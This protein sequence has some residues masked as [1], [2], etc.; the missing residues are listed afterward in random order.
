MAK[1]IKVGNPANESEKKAIQH[2]ANNLPKSWTI[3][4]NFELEAKQ[5]LE[6]DLAV[7][8]PHAVYLVDVKGIRGKFTEIGNKWFAGEN[9]LYPSPLV[10]LRQNTKILSNLLKNR[11]KEIAE[12]RKV[13]IHP[14]ILLT[15]DNADILDKDGGKISDII[16][17][18][19]CNKYFNDKSRVTPYRLNNINQYHRHVIKVITGGTP[20]SKHLIFGK[21]K[22]KEELF[23]SARYTE[24]RATRTEP[25]LENV[26]SILRIYNVNQYQDD[27]ASKAEDN[28]LSVAFRASRKIPD[29][30]RIISVNEYFKTESNDKHIFVFDDLPNE[31]ARMNLHDQKGKLLL[32][33]SIQIAYDILSGLEHVH[34]NEVIFRNINPKSILITNDFRARLSNLEFSRIEG[35]QN[36]TIASQINNFLEKNYQSPECFDE[37]SEASIAG[38]IYSA[39]VTIFEMLT[40]RLPFKN[41]EELFDRAGKFPHKPSTLNSNLANGF[42]KWLQKMCEFES[43]NRFQ[44]A[45]EAQIELTNLTKDYDKKITTRVIPKSKHITNIFDLPKNKVL[46]NRFEIQKKLGQGRFGVSYKVFDIFSD[47][48]KVMKLFKGEYPNNLDQMSQEFSILTKLPHYKYVIKT[49]GAGEI[50]INQNERIPYVLFEYIEGKSIS[51]YLKSKKFS[52]NDSLIIAKQVI[53]GLAHLHLNGVYHLDIKPVNIIWTNS[54]TRIIDFNIATLKVQNQST[55]EGTNKYLPPMF[56]QSSKSTHEINVDRDLYAFGIT[57]YE[58]L[59][60][61]YPFAENDRVNKS[62]PIDLRTH[63]NMKNINPDFANL[64]MKV[65]SPSVVDRFKSAESIMHEIRNLTI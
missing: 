7:L 34:S 49:E 25:E 15:N 59:T 33:Q 3:L 32:S 13:H 47:S 56:D 22:V 37:P 61:Q 17:L 2:L 8:S 28:L 38:D 31:S 65:I 27:K 5:K 23:K 19:D 4:H 46:D 55:E 48:S 1:I 29:H 6:I 52:V 45:S 24:F 50:F 60:C 18:A 57:I 54:E 12:I 40:G 35:D 39:G 58:C 26:T 10:K 44:S 20:S 64:I 41:A 16:K 14:T 42:N 11:F 62:K 53:A 63:Q 43:K 21:W 9:E 51:Q 36:L 30:S